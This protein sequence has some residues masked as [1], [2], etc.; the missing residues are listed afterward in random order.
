MPPRVLPHNLEA[1]ASVLGG[2]LLRNELMAELGDLTPEAFY[3]PQH[4]CVFEAMRGLDEAKKPIDEVLLEDE[5][6]KREKFEAVGGL[7]FLSRLALKVPTTEN[8]RY[9]AE[10]VRATYAARTLML[11]AADIAERG[12][13]YDGDIE[14]YQ[15]EAMAVLGDAITSSARTERRMAGDVVKNVAH[16]IDR[17]SAIKDGITG[18]PTGYLDLDHRTAGLQPTELVI[19]AGRPSMGKSALAMSI[20]ENT[21]ARGFPVLVFSLEMSAEQLVERLLCAASGVSSTAVRM[22]RLKRENQSALIASMS[23]LA[24]LPLAIDDTAGLSLAQVRARARRF[25]AERGGGNEGLGLVIVD[26]LQL[27]RG[28]KDARQQNREQEIAEIS[29]GLK[30]LAKELRWPVLALSQLNRG[31]ESRRDKRPML[32]DLRESGA[33]EQDA[34]LV[35]MLYRD[36]FY[37]PNTDEKYIA[38]L[39]IAKHRN[40][41]TGVIKLRFDGEYTRFSNLTLVETYTAR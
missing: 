27:M 21:A 13:S 11:A 9:Y 40:G 23:K 36:E 34:D 31:V 28:T 32:A 10:I 20:A 38:E 37:H 4:T 24:E 29:G 30:A 18:V 5:L 7:A 3:G 19:L 41:A 8:V 35:V 14:E 12:Y 33:I 26:Y 1:E 15:A 2:I 22:G 16:D 39:D 25:A 17:R 6:R